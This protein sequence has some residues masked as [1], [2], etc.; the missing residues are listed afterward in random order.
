MNASELL[1]K[2][3]TGHLMIVGEVRSAEIKESGVVDKNSGL[4]VSVWLLVY[5]V[6]LPREHEFLVAKIT[7]RV[8]RD[9][10]DPTA[11]PTGAERGKCY[12]FEVE[13]VERKH[14]FVSARMGLAEPEQIGP[15]EGVP[16]VDAPQGAAS[17]G[18]PL[19][20]V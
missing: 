11:Y 19:S 2:V 17:G 9:V 14:G 16:P 6:E 12:A 3:C 1:R 5:F 10:A 20:L 13:C 18:T 15:S 7:R 8:P 4:R